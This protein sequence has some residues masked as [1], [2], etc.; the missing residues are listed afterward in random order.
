[1]SIAFAFRTGCASGAFERTA[2][3][4]GCAFGASLFSFLSVSPASFCANELLVLAAN[5]ITKLHASSTVASACRGLYSNNGHNEFAQVWLEVCRGVRYVRLRWLNKI[6][7]VIVGRMGGSRT[8][9]RV[10]F[11]STGVDYRGWGASS[12]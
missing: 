1:M 5:A 12:N 10:R 8:N 3:F 6:I 7:P 2:G 4:W 9:G 11:E